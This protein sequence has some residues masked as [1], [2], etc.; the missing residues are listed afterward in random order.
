MAIWP[1]NRLIIISGQ[2]EE[3]IKKR[4]IDLIKVS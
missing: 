4:P 1:V 3:F 2:N